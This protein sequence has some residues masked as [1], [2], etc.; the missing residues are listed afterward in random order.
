MC[1][2]DKVARTL[3]VACRD[4]AVRIPI[5]SPADTQRAALS[6]RDLAASIGFY[7]SK[8]RKLTEILERIPAGSRALSGDW[9]PYVAAYLRAHGAASERD[10]AWLRRHNIDRME[11]WERRSVE[12]ILG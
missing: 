8:G 5:E 10:R 11:R 7:G 6:A 9:V 2:A 3:T 4:R 12:D 1:D